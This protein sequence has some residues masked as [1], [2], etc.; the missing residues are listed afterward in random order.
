MI[1]TRPRCDLRVAG[2]TSVT[3]RRT[4]GDGDIMS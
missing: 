3:E 4:I 1:G 2:M